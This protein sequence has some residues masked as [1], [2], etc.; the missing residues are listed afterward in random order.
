MHGPANA[1]SCRVVTLG[2]TKIHQILPVQTLSIGIFAKK[3]KIYYHDDSEATPGRL[4]ELSTKMAHLE[5]ESVHFFSDSFPINFSCFITLHKKIKKSKFLF[6]P[7]SRTYIIWLVLGLRTVVSEPSF[8]DHL[9]N[10]L[11]HKGLFLVI[12]TIVEVTHAL[13]TYYLIYTCLEWFI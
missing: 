5:H 3:Q 7:H 4:S 6:P 2:E 11:F 13:F 1:R 9:I 10:N 12:S 8:F